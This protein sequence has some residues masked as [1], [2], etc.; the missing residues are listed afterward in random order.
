MPKLP[1]SLADTSTTI[2]PMDAGTYELEIDEVEVGKSKS[3]L[4]MVT[5]VYKVAEGDF[6]G[7]Q[8]RDYFVLE[9]KQH[10]ANEAGLRGFKRLVVA[11]LGEERANAEDFDTDELQGMRVTAVIKQD[12]YEDEDTKEEIINNKIKKILPSA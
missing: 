7:R 9:T 12:S 8:I 3:K 5:V 4:D 11:A 1:G 10:E 2:V 6:K